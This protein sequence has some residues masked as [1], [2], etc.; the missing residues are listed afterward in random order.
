MSVTLLSRG[1]RGHGDGASD[2]GGRSVLL[3]S[4]DKGNGGGDGRWGTGDGVSLSLCYERDLV[5]ARRVRT[6]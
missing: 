6:W 2:G 5:V 3:A 4:E 1:E